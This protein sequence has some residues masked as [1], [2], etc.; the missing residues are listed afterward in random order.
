MSVD[1]TNY[2]RFPDLELDGIIFKVYLDGGFQF[3]AV[4]ARDPNNSFW[5][6]QELYKELI[7]SII[8]INDESYKFNLNFRKEVN[9]S[10]YT[11]DRNFWKFYIIRKN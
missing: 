10:I 5:E 2:I 1:T 3:Q 6:Y 8:G 11:K 9:I 4:K 7:K